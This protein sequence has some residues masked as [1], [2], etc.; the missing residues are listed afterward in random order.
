[1]PD[2]LSYI[3]LHPAEITKIPRSIRKKMEEAFGPMDP[4][5]G[6]LRLIGVK[7]EQDMMLIDF[8]LPRLASFVATRSS[9]L[10]EQKIEKILEIIVDDMP[11][12]TID[13]DMQIENAEMRAEYLSKTLLFSTEE[14]CTMSGIVNGNENE[15]ALSWTR[16]RKIFAVTKSKINLYPSF[17]FEDGSPKPIIQQILSILPE[18]M[19]SWQIA[20]WFDCM[21]GWL[22]GAK[23]KNCLNQKEEILYAAQQIAE[24]AIG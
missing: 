12:L 5:S 16:D 15:P 14:V 9:T 7:S 13:M 17:Q 2:S 21:N 23:P 3:D 20:F 6:I 19:S 24:P 11:H 22:K 10:Q 4:D 18:E 1:M 8:V